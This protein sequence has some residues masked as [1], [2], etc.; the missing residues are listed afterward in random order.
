MGFEPVRMWSDDTGTR[1]IHH[2][3]NGWGV[4]VWNQ[5]KAG[6]FASPYG[7]VGLLKAELRGWELSEAIASG[8][9]P[10]EL[11]HLFDTGGIGRWEGLPQLEQIMLQVR[12][13][14]KGGS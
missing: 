10:T 5:S 2:F 14:N 1:E 13:Y 7:E 6:L 9:V 4:S 3:A 8:R 12:R 11:G